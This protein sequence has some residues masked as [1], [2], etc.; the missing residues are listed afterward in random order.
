MF[1]FCFFSS[2]VFLLLDFLSY[3]FSRMPPKLKRKRNLKPPPPLTGLNFTFEAVGTLGQD[4][5]AR[6]MVVDGSVYGLVFRIPSHE[7]FISSAEFFG[8]VRSTHKDIF[9]QVRVVI[10]FNNPDDP[11]DWELGERECCCQAKHYDG[12]CKHIV[13]LLYAMVAKH[14]YETKWPNFPAPFPK[15]EKLLHKV[16]GANPCLFPGVEFDLNWNDIIGR[17]EE[18]PPTTRNRGATEATYTFISL[19]PNLATAFDPP[20]P[21]P[22]PS[23]K[24]K[25]IP[26]RLLEKVY[27]LAFFSLPFPFPDFLL[28]SST[29]FF[30][31][32]TF[33]TSNNPH[34]Q[35]MTLHYHKKFPNQDIDSYWRRTVKELKEECRSKNLK[36]S[37]NKEELVERLLEREKMLLEKEM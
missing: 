30:P 23:K 36:L 10:K 3:S 5:I 19:G 9:Y 22:P 18:A 37:G 4:E 32:F 12:P 33:L 31:F 17:L 2:F 13:A 35:I 7:R 1:F 20:P 34:P 29:P 8:W 21:A 25:I 26:P 15:R 16:K 11:K 27:T 14:H 6:L 28:L 24:S